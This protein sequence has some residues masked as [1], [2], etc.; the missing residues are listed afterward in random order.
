MSLV[1][2]QCGCVVL[3]GGCVNPVLVLNLNLD[4]TYVF[5]KVQD[6]NHAAVILG[7]PT[8]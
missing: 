5:Y 4:Y 6:K 3:V 7:L 8:T 2:S 1:I